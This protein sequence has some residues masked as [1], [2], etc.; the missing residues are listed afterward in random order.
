MLDIDPLRL[1]EEDRTWTGLS[2]QYAVDAQ[3]AK[4]VKGIRDWVIED[5]TPGWGYLAEALTE[6][7]EQVN[8]ERPTT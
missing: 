1:T 8:I 7:L 6:A 2:E 4:A 3:L 5:G